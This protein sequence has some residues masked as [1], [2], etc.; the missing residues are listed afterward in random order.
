MFSKMLVALD[1]GSTCVG[2]FKQAL[3]LAQATGARLMLLSILEPEGNGSLVTS[4]DYGYPLPLG[5]DNS[6]WLDLYRKAE[7]RGLDRLR[8]F[9]D[10]AIAAGVSTEFTQIIGSPG[11][12]I[13]ALAKTWEADLIL[14]GS[15][16]RTGLSELLLGSVS[17]YVMHHAPCSVLVIDG[18]T[19]SEAIAEPAEVATAKGQ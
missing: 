4:A 16:G 2:L 12:E 13:C 1:Q 5:I 8:N 17:N 3:A 9:T 14:V 18:Q 6:I 7:T 10:Q 19:L 11:R 15:H